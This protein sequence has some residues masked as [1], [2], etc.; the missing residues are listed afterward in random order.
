M[1][2]S[3]ER[4]FSVTP[5]SL[6]IIEQK[7][8]EIGIESREALAQAAN[9]SLDVIQK[10]LFS[11]KNVDRSTIEAISKALKIEP[12]EII[13]IDRWYRHSKAAKSQDLGNINW[14]KICRDVLELQKQWLTSYPLGAANRRVQD[15]YIP[16]GLIERQ[17][18]PR[19][20]QDFDPKNWSVQEQ[21]QE[22]K[23]KPVSHEEFFDSVLKGHSP[24]SK[25]KR[26][27]VVG[28]PGA[29]KTTLLQEIGA[30]V[31][32]VP[33]WID[34]ASLKRDDT[35]EDYLL[36]KW[37]K[38]SLSLVRE[39]IPE[40]VPNLLEPSVELK[41]AFTELFAQ[42]EIWLLLDG[43]DEMASELGQPLSW[44]AQQLRQSGWV[45]QARV[46]L[47]SRLN[48]WSADGDRLGEFDTYRN[49]DFEPKQVDEFIDKWFAEEPNSNQKLKEELER[50]SNRIK[51]LIRNPLRLT[52]LCITWKGVG[53][54]LPETKAGLYQRLV[55]A[56]YKW[57]DDKQEFVIDPDKRD[58][59]HQQ[60]GELSKT[61]LDSK[62]SRFRLRESFITKFLGKPN[63]KHSLFWWAIKLGWLNS[64]GLPSADENDADEPVYAFFH[65]TFQ[66]Y[67]AALAIDDW[68]YFLP[69]EHKNTPVEGKK[70]RIFESQWKEVMLFWLGRS[71]ASEDKDEFIEK[72]IACKDGCMH[73]YAYQTINSTGDGIK[74]YPPSHELVERILLAYKFPIGTDK[75]EYSQTYKI[76]EVFLEKI[77]IEWRKSFS[78]ACV[79]RSILVP[80]ER[81]C[82]SMKFVSFL[83]RL[84]FDQAQAYA[85]ERLENLDSLLQELSHYRYHSDLEI[86]S[87][88]NDINDVVEYLGNDKDVET[89]RVATKKL[90]EII[91]SN[92]LD[93]LNILVKNYHEN[94]DETRYQFEWSKLKLKRN[95]SFINEN[96]RED[97]RF[98]LFAWSIKS[99]LKHKAFNNL[100]SV[101]ALVNLLR[102][103]QNDPLCAQTLLQKLIEVIQDTSSLDSLK[104]IVKQ[105][106]NFLTHEIC[107]NENN[108]YCDCYSILW[109][110]AEKMSY[111][112]F[113]GAWHSSS[114]VN[115]EPSIDDEEV[116]P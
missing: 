24:K 36:Q 95:D 9:L 42:N 53:D 86:L 52:L 71:N 92:P 21:D 69:R 112:E 14:Q 2:S 79:E 84:G 6:A 32:G 57:K 96:E 85:F 76:D 27:A 115:A 62:E 104:S 34:L 82:L 47:T 103:S 54:R 31:D 61:A 15:V 67:F 10:K 91:F 83:Q 90:L 48:V 28:E 43:A 17:S 1:G 13:E 12:T 75:N 68:D 63:K 106:K 59:L 93:T 105:M 46:V 41:Q 111:P 37:L 23:I 88:S 25:G 74:E 72:L 19:T 8:R 107:I 108:F 44:V 70:Y 18:K 45:A 49:L 16:L 64:I 98:V 56:H 29:G 81:A 3:R 113:Y 101:N 39:Y 22:E 26:I 60:L 109:K 5:E 40:A 94:L 7:M 80:L 33:I 73:F 114:S 66:E 4:G 11:G 78:R 30:K 58:R 77:E 100:I 55:N 89:W 97:I 99:L 116:K 35:L 51:S 87:C 102:T 38:S 110:C 65:P 20:K 50:S